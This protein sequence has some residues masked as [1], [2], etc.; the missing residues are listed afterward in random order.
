[1]QSSKPPSQAN[2][3]TPKLSLRREKVRHM[4]VR[5]G[6]QTGCPGTDPTCPGTCPG[7]MKFH[8]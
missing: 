5:T 8:Y 4:N 1:M 3:E 7:S 6:V 2:V